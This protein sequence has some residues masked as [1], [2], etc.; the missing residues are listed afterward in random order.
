MSVANVPEH[1]AFIMDGNSRWAKLRGKSTSAGHK[2]GV[3]SV[4]KVLNLA[5]ENGVRVITL[6]AFSS[7]NWLRP[8]AEVTALMTLLGVYLKKEVKKLH[9]D[10]IQL[11]FIGRRDQ[12]AKSLVKKMAQAETLTANNSKAILVIAVDYGG[13]W[14]I[15]NAAKQLVSQVQSGEISVDEITPER[16]GN[17]VA[18]SDLPPPDLCVR[19]AGE[20]RISNFLLWQMAYSEFYFIE[21]FWP[22]FSDD[23]MQ[24]L[25]AAYAGRERRF[26][27][28]LESNNS[29]GA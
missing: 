29:S 26:G 12:L 25:L 6:Y 1:I 17:Y 18:L 2:A 27:A 5:V 9:D 10:N 13:Q 28:R 15:A 24:E 21:T 11:R 3:E 8:K 14:D 19:T 20:Q 16:L 4:R 22:D 23:D 7:E